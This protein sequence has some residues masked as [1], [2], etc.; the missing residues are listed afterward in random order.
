MQV[1]ILPHVE[2]INK[3]CEVGL[4]YLDKKRKYKF[5]TLLREILSLTVLYKGNL[6]PAVQACVPILRGINAGSVTVTVKREVPAAATLMK[7]MSKCVAAWWWGY[8][9][10]N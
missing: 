3:R 6:V 10:Y 8:W 2:N 7:K 1:W 9:N 4:K 5:T